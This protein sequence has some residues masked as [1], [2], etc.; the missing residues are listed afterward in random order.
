MFLK[1]A[2]GPWY[3][4]GTGVPPNVH[5]EDLINRGSELCYRCAAVFV[6]DIN[7]RF[8]TTGEV[9]DCAV[10]SDAHR[11]KRLRSSHD[12]PEAHRAQLSRSRSFMQDEHLCELCS[13]QLVSFLVTRM[14]PAPSS[15]LPDDE[16]SLEL[17]PP[18]TA[19]QLVAC[20]G[21]QKDLAS[22]CE[23]LHRRPTE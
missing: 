8:E 21:K 15:E 10:L 23:I 11:D 22:F 18:C 16:E 17:C 5:G 12:Q 14:V 13:S 7:Y 19:G 9:G 2:P 1:L 4:D 3:E 20:H 6:L